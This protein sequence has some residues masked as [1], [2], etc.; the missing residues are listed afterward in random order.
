MTSD[1]RFHRQHAFPLAAFLLLFSPLLAGCPKN[2]TPPEG[3]AFVPA[4]EFTMGSNKIDTEGKA[5]EF[6]TVKPFFM[7]EHP[8]R[9]VRLPGFFMD[10]HELSN[11]KYRHFIAATGS[12]PPENWSGG[13]LPAGTE[14]YP[15]TFVNWYDAERY[16]RWAGKR[17][18]TGAEWEKAARGTDGREYPWGNDFNPENGNTGDTGIGAMSDVGQFPGGKSPYGVEDMA[19]NAWEWTADWYKPYP[20][21]DY[22]NE[23]F[24][25]KFKV[26]R[27]S[28]WGGTGH[29]SIAHFYRSNYRFYIPP[30][31]AF[32]DA[33]FRCVQGAP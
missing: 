5:S 4:G 25:E 8:E 3:M 27:G 30:E 33:G 31:G 24:G 22:H 23:N 6:G 29:Y 7:D 20:G 16:C 1:T 2:T 26:V 9:K 15:V 19:G 21:S 32:P 12:R 10:I 11:M 14:N 18:P 13:L 28:S 17:L